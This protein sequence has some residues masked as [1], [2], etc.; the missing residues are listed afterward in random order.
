M[1]ENRFLTPNSG[2]GSFVWRLPQSLPSGLYFV[3]IRSGSGSGNNGTTPAF[4]I[5]AKVTYIFTFG[6]DHESA[7]APSPVQ[8]CVD[9]E[10]AVA[11][12]YGSAASC[13]VLR[14]AGMCESEPEFSQ[15]FCNRT[16]AT[17]WCGRCVD[18][19]QGVKFLYGVNASCSQ[20][21]SQ[22]LCTSEAKA[23]QV[24]PCR[25]NYTESQHSRRCLPLLCIPP[26]A[27]K[28]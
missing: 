27:T 19:P 1:S 15:L 2:A 13:G 20:F 4:R 17:G 9:D 12:N 22:G 8:A 11:R 18:E 25:A 14:E 3:N 26:L 16:C 6:V 28:L 23:A 5:R 21:R 7:P 10:S 24:T